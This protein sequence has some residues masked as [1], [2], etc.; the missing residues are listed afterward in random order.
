MQTGMQMKQK[1]EK[2]ATQ[3]DRELLAAL[4][5]LAD[6]EGRQIQALVE[7]A[8]VSLVEERRQGKAR[9]HVMQAYQKSHGRFSS[10]YEKLAK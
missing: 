6:E 2:F 4:R 10:L 9:A 1:R 7:E 5:K 3:V 8:L